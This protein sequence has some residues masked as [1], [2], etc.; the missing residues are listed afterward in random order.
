MKNIELLPISEEAKKRLNEFA[1]QYK[2]YAQV[3]VEVVSFNEGRLIVRVEQ[4]ELV[5]GKMLTKKELVDRVRKMFEGEIPADWK[6]TV[7]AV[8]FDRKAIEGIN[9]S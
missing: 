8:D 7:S 1:T 3:L 5:N 9:A 4:K 2:R 6:L